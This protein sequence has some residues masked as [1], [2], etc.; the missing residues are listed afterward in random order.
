M[1][2]PLTCIL[3]VLIAVPGTAAE[4]QRTLRLGV[5]GSVFQSEA[6]GDRSSSG[7][8]L[9]LGY[10]SQSENE[11]ALTATRWPGA[12]FGNGEGALALALESNWYPVGA[13]GIAPY[14]QTGIAAF[15]YTT[16]PGLL[17]PSTTEWGFGFIAGFGLRAGLSDR[18]SASVEARLR[19]DDQIR[20]VEYRA[21]MHVGMGTLR[22]SEGKPGVVAPF[23]GSLSRLGNGPY[24]ASS[25]VAGV[26]LRRDK[27]AHSSL[28]VDIAAVGLE[29]ATAGPGTSPE[30][31]TA[32]LM[33]PAAELAATPRWGRPY[34]ALG[35]FLPG[36]LDGPDAGLRAGVHVGAGSEI[37]AS[38][39]ISVTLLSRTFWFQSSSGQHQFGLILGAGVGPRLH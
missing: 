16:A 4:A 2:R 24:V 27:S 37:F 29:A 17:A 6:S 39:R 14:V 9:Q 30:A 12:R 26:R 11:I 32:Y 22:P 3:S 35:P 8:G 33:I 7:Y 28:S 38:E 36:F 1:R 23:V 34:I 5:V 18:V 31:T 10:L 19:S 21:G 20:N 13:S 25:A 15:R